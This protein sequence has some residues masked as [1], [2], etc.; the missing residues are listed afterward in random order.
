[1]KINKLTQQAKNNVTHL[2]CKWIHKQKKCK[3][4][5]FNAQWQYLA[6][7]DNNWIKKCKKLAGI[8][9]NPWSLKLSNLN[10]M[11]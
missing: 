11:I 7:N 3:K 5:R 6:F 4:N 1:L 8:Y 10:K 2:F 9:Y